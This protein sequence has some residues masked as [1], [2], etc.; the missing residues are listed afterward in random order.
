MVNF[1]F[2][3]KTVVI[4]GGSSGIGFAT[5]QMF[6]KAGADVL[7]LS[8]N[9]ER[10]FQKEEGLFTY[11]VDLNDSK[12]IK[13]TFQKIKE[14]H[15][16]IDVAINAAAGETGIGKAIQDFSE[17]EFDAT[18]NVNLK[19]LWLCMKYQIERMKES[20]EKKCSIINISSVNGLGGVEG[21]SIYAATKAAVL[22]LTKSAALELAKSK[23]SVNAVVPGA[24]DTEL[25]KKAMLSHVNGD[26]EKLESVREEYGKHI[27]MN[28]IG[29]PKEIASLILFMASGTS[30]YFTGHSF[31]IDGG[32]S[33][34]FR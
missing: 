29:D 12:A 2:S 4:T 20:P 17:D 27:P 7:V 19:G 1:D 33:S 24:F 32:M 16:Y 23:I 28:R 31:I 10:N 13:E 26:E 5:A 9:P 34:R 30:D 3:G 6:L 21:G 25:L 15:P 14:M 18:V 11:P 8:R 22:A